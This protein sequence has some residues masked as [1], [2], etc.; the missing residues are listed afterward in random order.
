MTAAELVAKMR[1]YV[2]GRS[3]ECTGL[4]CL[5]I[6]ELERME[7][8]RAEYVR[9]RLEAATEALAAHNWE[10]ENERAAHSATQRNLDTEIRSKDAHIASLEARIAFAESTLR[11]VDRMLHER[12][13]RPL[14]QIRR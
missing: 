1:E 11:I 3:D 2:A 8:Q 10:T 14:R 13:L 12:Y 6:E 4:M 7:S 5:A 9:T